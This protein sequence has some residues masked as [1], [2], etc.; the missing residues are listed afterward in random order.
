LDT[1]VIAELNKKSRKKNLKASSENIS[2]KNNTHTLSE[3]TDNY[4]GMKSSSTREFIKDLPD[5]DDTN[6]PNKMH[7]RS[8]DNHQVS[9]H[10]TFSRNVIT[11]NLLCF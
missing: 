5:L 11:F 9:L 6:K 10:V 4:I 1:E 3:N 2:S 7:G 8:F